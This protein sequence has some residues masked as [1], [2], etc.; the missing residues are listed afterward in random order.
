MRTNPLEF[1]DTPA[2]HV[3]AAVERA[4]YLARWIVEEAGG[5]VTDLDGKP[6]DFSAGA[7]L[8]HNKGILVSNGVLHA[9][10]LLALRSVRL[11]QR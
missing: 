2:L 5:R 8:L 1:L 3:L 9:P 10:A 4:A 6:L 11:R 7:R